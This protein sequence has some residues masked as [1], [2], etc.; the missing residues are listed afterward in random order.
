MSTFTDD[1]TKKQEEYKIVRKIRLSGAGKTFL[2]L[3][4]IRIIGI[5]LVIA[6]G[7]LSS[8]LGFPWEVLELTPLLSAFPK[9]IAYPV[10]YLIEGSVFLS[11]VLVMTIIVIWIVALITKMFVI[12][13]HIEFEGE[14]YGK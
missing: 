9:L 13:T 6:V 1:V 2:V 7:W 10:L 5:G 3:L 8:S 4:F 14:S 11:L 12:E